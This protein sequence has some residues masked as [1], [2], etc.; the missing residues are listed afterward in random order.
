MEILIRISLNGSI[1][2][3][4][5]GYFGKGIHPVKTSFRQRVFC[6]ILL[7]KNNKAPVCLESCMLF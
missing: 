2:E 6:S 4:K 7:P 1:M 5:S 3:F